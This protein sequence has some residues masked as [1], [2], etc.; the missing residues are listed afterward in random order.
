MLLLLRADMITGLTSPGGDAAQAVNGDTGVSSP[1]PS[2]E[3]GVAQVRSGSCV[4]E[5]RHAARADLIGSDAPVWGVGG[6]VAGA[7]QAV[8]GSQHATHS[9]LLEPWRCIPT[10]GLFTSPSASLIIVVRV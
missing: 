6:A 2:R 7:E 9:C 3:S 4:L 8:G 5:R 10:T 1:D